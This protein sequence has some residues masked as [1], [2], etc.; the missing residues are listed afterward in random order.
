MNAVCWQRFDAFAKHSG[1][2]MSKPLLYNVFTLVAGGKKS[3]DQA[4][5]YFSYNEWL[6]VNLASLDDF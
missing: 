3:E 2:G 4:V 1:K 6:H 5:V